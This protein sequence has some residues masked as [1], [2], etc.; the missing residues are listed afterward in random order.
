MNVQKVPW[1]DE[2]P[3]TRADC[4]GRP[5]PCPWVGCRFHLGIDVRETGTLTLHA[6]RTT[7]VIEHSDGRERARELT[8]RVAGL[9]EHEP[10]TRADR[11]I[12]AFVEALAAAPLTCT[13]DVA[14]QGG[15]TLEQVGDLLH[16]TRE[17]VR[18]IE[19][20]ALRK[21]RANARPR[22]FEDAPEEP[23]DR[24]GGGL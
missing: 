12:D 11:A 13:L 6:G 7:E 5:R 16:I 9:P 14:D 19:T 23:M 21:L 20:L 22:H 10:V 17:R 4:A 3:L 8:R 2:R 24:F 1:G 15:V 18:Q